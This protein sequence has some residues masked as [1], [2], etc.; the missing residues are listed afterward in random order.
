M[1]RRVTSRGR[2][3][4]QYKC[5]GACSVLFIE[6]KLSIGEGKERQDA[7]AQVIAESDGLHL[8]NILLWCLQLL[9]SSV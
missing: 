1:E 3:E 4:Y 6:V 8:K 5:F 7:I 9:T 2:V